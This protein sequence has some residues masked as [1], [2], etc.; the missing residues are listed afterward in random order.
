MNSLDNG[1]PYEKKLRILYKNSKGE[2]SDRSIYIERITS[3]ENG[4]CKV[5]AFENGEKKTFL[6]SGIIEVLDPDTGDIIEYPFKYYMG[7]FCDYALF[8]TL[9]IINNYESEIF[10]LCFAA[11]L[12][13]TL[14]KDDSDIIFNYIQSKT[15]VI[16]DYSITIE[17]LPKIDQIISLKKMIRKFLKNNESKNEII[18][19]LEQIT[20]GSKN[21]M[22]ISL[23]E[24]IS[25]F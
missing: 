10:I 13:G 21:K 20:N 5:W 12:E 1:L 15:P 23:M 6:M 19:L 18:D 25:K 4:D 17:H 7:K 14:K 24:M 2:I 8:V 22:Q 3:K 9:N 16:L 11:G